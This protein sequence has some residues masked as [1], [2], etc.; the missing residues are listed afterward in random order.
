VSAKSSTQPSILSQRPEDG[1]KGS[2]ICQ[3]DIP[4]DNFDEPVQ[5]HRHGSAPLAIEVWVLRRLLERFGNPPISV[6]LWSGQELQASAA[7]PVG[8]VVIRNRA[9]LW[10]LFRDPLMAFGDSYCDGSIEIEGNL[11][12]CLAAMFRAMRASHPPSIA[13]RLM[14][15]L[16]P[17]PH[18]HTLSAS[19]SNV[20]H[21]YDIGNDFYKLWLD[22]RLLYSCAYFSR[23]SLTLEQAQVAKMDH[24]CRKLQLTSGQSVVDAGCGWGALALHM[25]DRYGAKVRAFNLSRE[26][27]DYA[28]ERLKETGLSCRVEFI[29]DDYRNISGPY[30]A[31]VSVGML[32][33][34]GPENYEELGRVI[35]RSLTAKGRGLIH[36]IGRNAARPMDPWAEKR[37]FP[38]AYPPSLREMM[39]IFEPFDFSVLD[40][41]NL[42]MHYARTLEHW[43]HRYENAIDAVTSMF[44]EKFVRM[45]RF[46]LASSL[47][48]FLTGHLQLF[49]VLFAPGDDNEVPWTRRYMETDL[50]GIC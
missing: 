20:E 2:S 16:R 3:L 23:P 10:R 50:Q 33:H 14:Q 19:H 31:F 28:R 47:A 9:A 43:L 8:R 18:P 35:N 29:A 48:T 38:G 22:D 45:W 44:D 17:H 4:A 7:C 6:L 24:I 15:R 27:V 41:E 37:I 34:V 40:V 39:D 46:Y 49:Q 36:C 42:R 30:D 13:A 12:D 5:S 1:A 25:A 26:Q 11:V 21:H 32:E